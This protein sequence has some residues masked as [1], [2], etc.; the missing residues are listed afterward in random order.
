MT[1]VSSSLSVLQTLDPS[2][3]YGEINGECVFYSDQGESDIDEIT[4]TSRQV[5]RMIAATTH[6][7]ACWQFSPVPPLD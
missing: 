1:E 2:A 4:G 7:S 6:L 3:L 5:L